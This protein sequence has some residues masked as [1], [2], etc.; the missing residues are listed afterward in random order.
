MATVSFGRSSKA[1]APR[2]WLETFRAADAWVL[3]A[4][5]AA[6]SM[7]PG[8]GELARQLR[9]GALEAGS[10]LVAAAQCDDPESNRVHVERARSRMLEARYLVYLSMRTGSIDT[11][12]YKLL[13]RKLDR[14]LRDVAGRR[15]A[16]S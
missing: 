13:A 12:R 7:A 5:E 15:S 6:A 10:A 3:A 2:G 11:K 9:Q 8:T 14:A 16:R 4:W 1:A